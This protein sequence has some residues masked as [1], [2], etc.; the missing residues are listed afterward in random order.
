MEDL[1]S[2][3]ISIHCI[4]WQLINTIFLIGFI[5]A[6]YYLIFKLPKKMKERDRRI[7][8]LERKINDMND[9]LDKMV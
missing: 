4:I 2:V 8:E 5:Y 9:K 3:D 1:G 7:D 6:I